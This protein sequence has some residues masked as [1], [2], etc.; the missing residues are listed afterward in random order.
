MYNTVGA[1]GEFYPLAYKVKRQ[2]IYYSYITKLIYPTRKFFMKST[3]VRR[4]AW[5]LSGG[6][7]FVTAEDRHL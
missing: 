2:L 5:E 7:F 4:N 6:Q 3:T 1:P